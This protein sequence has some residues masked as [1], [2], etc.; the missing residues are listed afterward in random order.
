M[1]WYEMVERGGEGGREG[2]RV[3][4][5]VRRFEWLRK[6][7]FMVM[8]TRD[9]YTKNAVCLSVCLSLSSQ[10]YYI[11][12]SGTAAAG[13]FSVDERSVIGSFEVLHARMG[14]EKRVVCTYV[15][16]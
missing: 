7:L 5:L 6:G 9:M 11:S 14:R 8:V 15:R 16:Y 1:G 13:G 3:R 2:G 10:S 4:W 12:L